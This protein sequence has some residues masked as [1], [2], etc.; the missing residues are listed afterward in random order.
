MVRIKKFES[1][2]INIPDRQS[3]YNNL[4][5]KV[6]EAE[7]NLTKFESQLKSE[8]L[9]IKS[10]TV[11]E[12]KQ[13]YGVFW[14][15]DY[16]SHFDG[17]SS[18]AIYDEYSG[19]ARLNDENEEALKKLLLYWNDM[20][21]KEKCDIFLNETDDAYLF[22]RRSRIPWCFTEKLGETFDE[23][24]EG[25]MKNNGNTST[26]DVF[27]FENNT[28]S[29]RITY[30]GRRDQGEMC[31]G[32]YIEFRLSSEDELSKVKIHEGERRG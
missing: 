22:P 19:A 2:E 21:F 1:L 7:S 12:N 5:A 13:V 11:M 16:Y 31:D 6:K 23:Y 29:F 26:F 30:Y 3:E 32:S 9:Y 4:V 27:K 25:E 10:G 24:D 20:T 17:H 14:D 8:G 18:D 15:I 28:N